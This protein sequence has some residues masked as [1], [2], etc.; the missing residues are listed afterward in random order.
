MM[1][2]A[3]VFALNNG[4]KELVLGAQEYAI[5]FYEKCGYE[6]YGEIFLDADIRHKM[7]KKK[8]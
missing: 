7:M 5:P 1:Q 4:Y 6:A 2:Q 8:V 3:D